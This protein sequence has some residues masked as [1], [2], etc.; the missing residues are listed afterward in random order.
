MAWAC[1]L[2]GPK[3][4][5]KIDCDRG[6]HGKNR[7]AIAASHDGAVGVLAGAAFGGGSTI[8]WACSLRTP[9]RVQDEW[10]RA[11]GLDATDRRAIESAMRADGRE[12]H[13]EVRA[14]FADCPERLLVYD[15]DRDEVRVP[16]SRRAASARVARLV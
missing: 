6:V 5:E 12:H 4:L 3:P 16:R 15:I 14:G 8:N 11:H 10:A 1:S 13:R 7:E 9:R 2:K